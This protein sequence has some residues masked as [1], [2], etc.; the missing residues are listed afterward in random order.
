MDD[1]VGYGFRPSDDELVGYYLHN[2]ILGNHWL[3]DRVIREVNICSFDPWD[4]RCKF[5]FLSEFLKIVIKS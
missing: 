1:L 5:R 3:V 4:L 2:K